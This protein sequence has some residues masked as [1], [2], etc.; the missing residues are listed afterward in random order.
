MYGK[1]TLVGTLLEVELRS[2]FGNF[3]LSNASPAE[4]G[5][6]HAGE[7]MAK[8][9]QRCS[10]DHYESSLAAYCPLVIENYTPGLYSSQTL[11]PE[12]ILLRRKWVQRSTEL[13]YVSK[14]QKKSKCYS[15][16]INIG[17]NRQVR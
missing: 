11:P 15:Q 8:E 7:R 10:Q 17:R 4:R 12:S 13:I 9:A 1:W 5:R 6:R 3:I 16:S 14:Y 2:K